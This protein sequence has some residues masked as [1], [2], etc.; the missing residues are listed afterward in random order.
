MYAWTFGGDWSRDSPSRLSK[1]SFTSGWLN[2]YA[3]VA[4]LHARPTPSRSAALQFGGL[5]A[6]SSLA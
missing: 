3:D 6:G 1:K 5:A 2:R 4:C